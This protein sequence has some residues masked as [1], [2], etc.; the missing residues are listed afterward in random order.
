MT[1]LET[2]EAKI[3]ELTNLVEKL[4]SRVDAIGTVNH[5]H[6]HVPKT[7]ANPQWIPAYGPNQ[8]FVTTTGLGCDTNERR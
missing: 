1:E 7:P 6:H 8:P 4:A 3:D 2:L 5:Y